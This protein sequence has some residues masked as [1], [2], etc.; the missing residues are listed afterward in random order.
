MSRDM[1]PRSGIVLALLAA[2]LAGPAAAVQRVETLALGAPPTAA[3]SDPARG[4][5]FVAT[6][7]PTRGRALAVLE[8]NGRLTTLPL[9]ASAVALAG[10]AAQRK[11][12]V[13]YAGG[14]AAVVQVDTLQATPVTLP[15][16]AVVRLLAG[17]RSPRGYL[18]GRSGR[19]ATIA[20][21]DLKSLATRAATLDDGLPV[22]LAL[23]EHGGRLFVLLAVADR[24]GEPPTSVL[25]VLDAQTLAP[26]ETPL[27]LGRLPR[28]VVVSPS[29]DEV[30]VLDHAEASRGGPD[31]WRPTLRVLDGALALQRQVLLGEARTSPLT[32]SL[33]ADA[34]GARI[35]VN[36]ATA[37]RVF[38]VHPASGS[39][40]TTE[41]ESPAA[42]IGFAATGGLVAVMPQPG[43][44]A[45]L[46]PGGERLDTVSI[47]HAL[48][49]EA[50]QLA[51]FSIAADAESG[52]T[53]VANGAE[54]TLVRLP[55]ENS[56]AIV[57]LTDLWS[58]PAE[59]GW[60]VFIEHQGL[61]VFAAL[62]DYGAGGEASWLTMS[63]GI[64][65]PDG[66]FSGV[67]FRT[68][69]PLPVKSTGIAPVGIMRIVP[70][71]DGSAQLTAV[72]DGASSTRRI[73][74]FTLGDAPRTCRW[75]AGA[76]TTSIARAN[77]TALWS[78]PT[79]PGWGLAVSHRASG[80]FAVLFTY[81]DENRPSWRVMS[82][83]KATAPGIFTGELYRVARGQVR[84]IGAMTLRFSAADEGSV[85]WRMDGTEFRAPLLR[86]RFGPLV[87]RCAG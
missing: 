12:L 74:R 63:N 82:R 49:A 11:V 4:T 87:S 50:A 46:G 13:A 72:V 78:N 2:A 23:D 34:T 83:G 64:R 55:R 85:A 41:L 56:G 31:S 9:Q 15:A 3:W 68:Q 47:G 77:F 8:R 66:S 42:A 75:T 7:T 73:E 52:D 70:S 16:S 57:N 54:G 53:F 86:Q 18:L 33:Q 58:D 24:A 61:T 29:G 5:L 6:D 48:G 40:A 51:S 80:V 36:D 20:S 32:G 1:L 22:D 69:G 30:M 84:A 26:V 25:H 21:V 38:I 37:A 81:D 76:D 71:P 67:L 10:S 17:E 35:A 79:D 44:A 14:S 39:V 27:R 65:Q 43:T 19:D 59:P 60:G 62:F 45:L 28:A